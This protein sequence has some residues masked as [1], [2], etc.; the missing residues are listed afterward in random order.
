MLHYAFIHIDRVYT[1]SVLSTGTSLRHS[2]EL[3][4]IAE[5]PEWSHTA[6]TYSIS[7]QQSDRDGMR[8]GRA[9]RWKRLWTTS[10]SELPP[11]LA[12][13]FHGFTS[14]H[15]FHT[16][17]R[18]FTESCEFTAPRRFTESSRRVYGEFI[19]EVRAPGIRKSLVFFQK[20]HSSSGFSCSSRVH[21]IR[22]VH[23]NMIYVSACVSAET[24]LAKSR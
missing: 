11:S 4:G 13:M 23:G 1:S 17:H 16:I 14:S 18:E 19:K 21:R 10:C 22:N 6:T 2:N 20:V 24:W 9:I 3:S 5:R 7:Q 8:D 12:R 15:T